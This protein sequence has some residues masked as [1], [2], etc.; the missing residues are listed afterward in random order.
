MEVSIGAPGSPTVNYKEWEFL[1]DLNP[2]RWQ[3]G[4]N[5][6]QSIEEGTLTTITRSIVNKNSTAMQYSITG[7][8]EDNLDGSVTYGDIPDW[9]IVSPTG[10]TL[11]PGEVKPII[12]VFPQDLVAEDYL[13]QI[14]VVG[15]QGNN[16]INVDLRVVCKGP[17]WQID[18]TQYTYTMNMTLQL[19][20][21]GDL[22]EDKMDRVAAFITNAETGLEE[23][24]G[25]SF[26]QYEPTITPTP[27][28]EN[29]N[30]EPGTYFAFLTLYSNEFSGED[31]KLKIWDVS[32]CT[33]YGQ[34]LEDFTYEADG[35]LGSPLEPQV[36]HT[37]NLISRTIPIH[38]GWNWISYNVDLPDAAINEALGS[39]TQPQNSLIKN[40]TNFAVYSEPNGGFTGNMPELTHRTMY[41]YRSD[42]VDSL[43]MIGRPIDPDTVP[44][45]ILAGWNWIGFLPQQGMPVVDALASLSPLNGDIVKSQIAF[46]QYVAGTGWIGNLN[47]MSSPNGYL[48][49]ISNDGTLQYPN[50]FTGPAI[51]ELRNSYDNYWQTQPELYQYT[52]NMIGI[53]LDETNVLEDGDEVAAFVNGELRGNGQ[54]VYIESLNAHVIFLTA[55]ANDEGET[56]SFKFYDRSTEKVMDLQEQFSFEANAVY[57]MVDA[58]EVWTP[59]SVSSTWNVANSDDFEVYPNPA[60]ERVYLKFTN[61]VAERIVVRI[62]DALGREVERLETQAATGELTLEWL[63]KDLS[64][65]LYFI[66]LD[67]ADSSVTRKVRITR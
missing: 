28:S 22:S 23:L 43:I 53:V 61:E 9:M 7:P 13:S 54:T 18:P 42:A 5:I 59:A 58:P 27:T 40:Q 51:T 66:T 1:V 55:Y 60:N 37:V 3:A 41:Q 35:I 48:L 52:M 45:D 19:D 62:T 21:E 24:R 38:Q 12:F 25:W 14:N 31:I 64:E 36:V 26:V 50:S 2:L 32:D 30:P 11:D 8:R 20:I 4:S 10:G 63:P 46:A 49:R 6:E 16:T 67:R 56:M 15:T 29:P 17:V 34:V 33:L 39:L 65:G 47:F 44:I 57:G